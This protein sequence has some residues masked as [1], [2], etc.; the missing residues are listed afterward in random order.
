MVITNKKVGHKLDKDGTRLIKLLKHY[1]LYKDDR[2]KQILIY[3]HFVDTILREIAE[4]KNL[5]IEEVRASLPFEIKNLLNGKLARKQLEKRLNF[6]AMVW[7]KDRNQV[8]IFTREKAKKWETL[9]LQQNSLTQIIQGRT[10]CP[11][12]V[13]GKVRILLKAQDCDR[14]KKGEVLVTFMTSPDFMPA[15]RKAS[16]IVTNLGGVT[17]HAAII[18]RELNIPCIVGTK[19][20]TQAL[21]NG[22]LVEVDADRGTVKILKG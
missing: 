16:A 6:C 11:G 18:S 20:A 14:M 1:S 22:D 2:K 5:S 12:K 17:S 4:R 13:T 3:L 21:K 19:I 7:Q 10:A 15:M 9:T 8:E